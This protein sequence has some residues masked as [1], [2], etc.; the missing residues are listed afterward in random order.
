MYSTT[1]EY[2]FLENIFLLICFTFSTFLSSMKKKTVQ[3][4]LDGLL[5]FSIKNKPRVS[6]RVLLITQSC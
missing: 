1:Q 3:A 6:F 2:D 5:S 4:K